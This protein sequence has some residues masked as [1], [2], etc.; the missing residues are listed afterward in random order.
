MVPSASAQRA[1]GATGGRWRAGERRQDRG[2]RGG[3][4]RRAYALGLKVVH[5]APTEI[6]APLVITLPQPSGSSGPGLWL[7]YKV[8]EDGGITRE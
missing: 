1:A 3:R 4:G 6:Y 7:L 2:V 5:L 8:A